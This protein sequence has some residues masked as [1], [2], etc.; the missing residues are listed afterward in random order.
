[1][2]ESIASTDSG[3]GSEPILAQFVQELAEAADPAVVVARFQAA[4][5]LLA[6]EFP[7]MADMMRKVEGSSPDA[8]TD[9]PPC[10]GGFRLIRRI[11]HGGMGE[12]FEAVEERL[13]RRVAVKIVHR[14]HLSPVHRARFLREQWVLAQ[15]HQTHIVPIFAAG[16]QG[17]FQYFAMPYIEG[18]ALHQALELARLPRNLA[19]GRDAEAV[20][21]GRNV[22]CEQRPVRRRHGARPWRSCSPRRTLLPQLIAD[23]R[24][25]ISGPW[26]S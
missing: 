2:N 1:M 24:A 26:R 19:G 17:P 25:T 14:Q 12:V 21:T 9:L 6:G 23:C 8:D 16:E 4:Y 18:A 7:T 5:P 22:H 3:D 13:K 10:L 15:L 11:A 20:H